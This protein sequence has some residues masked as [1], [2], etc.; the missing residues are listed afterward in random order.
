MSGGGGPEE[1]GGGKRGREKYAAIGDRRSKISDN[2]R[3]RK[4]Q[5]TRLIFHK[6]EKKGIH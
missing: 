1:N 2:R 5:E 3:N 6:L 4:V